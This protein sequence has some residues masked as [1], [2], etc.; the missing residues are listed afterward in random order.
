MCP[1]C[2]CVCQTNDPVKEFDGKDE[3]ELTRDEIK[4]PE[5]W[6]WKEDW[7][8]DIDRAVDD[9]GMCIIYFDF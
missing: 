2:V 6:L 8:I 9:K 4:C 7:Q 5:G 1:L 3:K